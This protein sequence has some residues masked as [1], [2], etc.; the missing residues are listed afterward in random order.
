MADLVEALY[1]L[2]R[3]RA[4]PDSPLIAVRMVPGRPGLRISHLPISQSLAH[5][6]V[7]LTGEPFHQHQSLA[8]ASLRRNEPLALVGGHAARQTLHLLT[9]ELLRA[10]APATVLVVAPDEAAAAAQQAGF[11]RI[12]TALGEPLRVALAGGTAARAAIAA[13]I[14]VATPTTLHE[15]LL[16]YHER[17]WS[18]FWSRLRL[19]VVAEAHTYTGLA[20]TH[21]AALLLRAQRLAPLARPPQLAATIAPVAGADEALAQL[22]GTAWRCIP[23]EDVPMPRAALALWRAPGERIREAAALAL[24]LA[25]AGATVHLTCAP[26]EVTMLRALIG[27]FGNKISVGP[28]PLIAQ[29]QIFVGI[30]EASAYLRPAL[31]GTALTVLVLD[32]D[33]A[34]RTV[35][36]LATLEPAQFPLF[37]RPPPVWVVAPGNAYVTAQHLVCAANERPFNAAEIEAWQAATIIPRLEASEHLVQ[38]PGDELAWQPFANSDDPYRG[39]DLHSAGDTAATLRDDQGSMLGTLDG[40]AFDRWGFV[41]AAL[42]PLRGGFRVTARDEIAFSLV[43]QTSPEARRTLPLR[44]CTV[45]VRDRREQRLVRGRE[46]A[47][48]RVVVDEEIY[49]YLEATPANAPIEMTIEPPITISWSAPALWLDLPAALSVDGQMVGWSLTAALPL[50][51]LATTSALVPVYDAEARRIYFVDAQPGGSG[52][53]VWLFTELES[54]LPLAYDVAVDGINDPLFEAV[55]Y[56]DLAWL[57]ALLGS[58]HPQPR[59]KPSSRVRGNAARTP[60]AQTVAERPRIPHE[61]TNQVALDE[62]QRQAEREAQAQAEREAQVQAEREAQ[63]QA[64][65]EVWAA[66]EQAARQTWEDEQQQLREK[67]ERER[68]AH[69]SQER[70]MR[71]QAVYTLRER[72]VQ[73]E[74]ALQVRAERAI[75]KHEARVTQ[76]RAAC[77]E[78]E[79]LAREREIRAALERAEQD[80]QERP[81][82]KREAQAAVRAREQAAQARTVPATAPPSTETH[83]PAAPEDTLREA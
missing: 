67:R 31:D 19:I 74:R 42:P 60:V 52:L 46:L 34:E 66:Q 21:L 83:G 70:L 26:F 6:W 14:V 5:V 39:F 22:T 59:R 33:P 58:E 1:T 41:G 28:S 36:R 16:R 38:L 77:L 3:Q 29:V 12:A 54:L 20:A 2:A 76:E 35:A 18:A 79:R 72:Q 17:A 64:E 57:G 75:R 48:G 68:A 23:A 45:R 81:L 56:A 32:D 24:G 62:Q 10:E 61:A 4:C 25:H 53:A 55:A 8:L 9:V 40:A 65:R 69:Q 7:T 44:R 13:H 71:D 47:W 43:V 73:A 37:D 82:R 27:T 78:R 50:C 80:K 15:R 51:A 30:T 11:T 49:G 63:V